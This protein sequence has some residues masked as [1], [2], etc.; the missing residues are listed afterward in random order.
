[1]HMSSQ[2]GFRSRTYLPGAISNSSK[3]VFEVSRG[4]YFAGGLELSSSGVSRLVV[5]GLDSIG[6]TV[7]HK[8]YGDDN[9]DFA[10]SS[11]AF[12]TFLQVDSTFFYA[13][14]IFAQGGSTTAGIL[15]KFDQKGDTMWSR[16][17]FT[18]SVSHL[19]VQ[20]MCVARDGGFWL[21]GLDEGTNISRR[22]LLIKTDE[23]G[24][25]QWRKLISKPVPNLSDGRAILQDSATGSVIIA[26]YQDVGDSLSWQPYGQLLILDSIGNFLSRK[27]LEP[28][29]LTDLVKTK[30]N[31]YVLIGIQNFSMPLQY[32]EHSSYMIKFKV[33]PAFTPVWS[34]YNYDGF[35]KISNYFTA[36]TCAPNGDL[37]VAGELTTIA[38]T[39]KTKNHQVRIVSVSQTGKVKWRRLY[40][41]SP[42]STKNNI[43][44]PLSINST[45]DG[46]CIVAIRVDN[47]GNNPLFYVKY[48]SLGCD[49]T[50]IYCKTPKGPPIGTSIRD[51][52]KNNHMT[53]SPCPA[54]DFLNIK[55]GEEVLSGTMVS[56]LDVRGQKVHSF[57][58]QGENSH[59][60]DI[61]GW[62][63]GLYFIRLQSDGQPVRSEK[64]IKE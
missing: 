56:I 40:D 35:H 52:Y 55:L 53:L 33:K 9:L 51:L 14:T 13:G 30:D 8:Q 15:V 46:G 10:N 1:M 16:K 18:D 59:R 44:R 25:E 50:E 17:F 2:G 58:T 42:D 27:T 22:T 43:L 38:V 19:V 49:S 24:H 20:G 3:A 32:P 54:Q 11:L 5:A 39:Q 6:K 31:S 57:V 34:I 26:G 48:D 41:Y 7:W 12:R 28:G 64:F 21:T 61:R 4:H 37:L 62:S 47:K 29:I 36:V 60:I 23:G 45:A 63:G